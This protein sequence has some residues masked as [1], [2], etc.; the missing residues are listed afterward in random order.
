MPSL[1]SERRPTAL[2]T[3]ATAGIRFCTAAGLA[4]QG[5]AVVVTGRDRRR[6]EQAARQLRHRAGHDAVTFIAVDHSVAAENTRLA[7]TVASRMGSVDLLVNSAGA[8][9]PS[10]GSP[11]TATRPRWR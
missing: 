9:T 10:A 5:W 7:A 4:Q 6:G 2:V 8:S 11:S 3:G 1:P